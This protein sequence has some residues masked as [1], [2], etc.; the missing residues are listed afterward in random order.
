VAVEQRG[1]AELHAERM[2]G[3]RAA[4]RVAPA[5]Q[6]QR[7]QRSPNAAVFCHTNP[8]ITIAETLVGNGD[9]ALDYYLRINPSA[10]EAISNQHRCEPYV[11]AQMIAGRTHPPTA[12]PRTRG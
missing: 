10:R 11:Y 7:A 9:R 8:W 3:E 1:V 6:P 2:L 4:V 5:G 12:R